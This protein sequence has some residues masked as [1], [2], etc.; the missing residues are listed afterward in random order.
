MFASM[1][2][3]SM[4]RLIH[5]LFIHTGHR[6]W[7]VVV[8]T[9]LNAMTSALGIALILPLL[10]LL[11]PVPGIAPLQVNWLNPE[12]LNLESILLLYLVLVSLSVWIN[13]QTMVQTSILVQEYTKHLRVRLFETLFASD[14][15]YIAYQKKSD[16][17]NLFTLEIA[18]ISSSVTAL[19]GLISG[20]LIMISHIVLAWYLSPRLTGFVL[21]SGIIVFIS[22]YTSLGRVRRLA[23]SLYQSNQTWQQRLHEQLYG[24]KEIRSYGIEAR[25]VDFFRQAT[26]E[27]EQQLVQFAKEQ[28]K[29][30]TVFKI[31]AAAV[32]SLFF[33]ISL[34]VLQ[35]EVSTLLV[36]VL[37]FGR[38]WPLFAA[39]QK[40]IQ[41]F[42]SGVPVYT[43]L[44]NKMEAVPKRSGSDE[45]K[46][47]FHETLVIDR[48]RYSYGQ[49]TGIGVSFT[50]NAGQMVA[51]M[52]ASGTGKSTFLD[53]LL[54]L[55]EPQAGEIRVDGK[56][57]NARR[58]VAWREQISYIPQSAFLFHGTI[59]E[60]ILHFNPDLTDEA[61]VE[62]L[63]LAGATFVFDL[64]DGI[65]TMIGDFGT[66]LS[67]G[68]QQKIILARA[69][70]KKPRILLLDE[71]T[72][73]LDREQEVM[74]HDTLRQLTSRMTILYITHRREIGQ[75]ADAIYQMETGTFERREVNHSK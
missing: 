42:L 61:L 24:M 45:E 62:A 55:L 53:L 34:S 63:D 29:P 66:R 54:G 31:V 52:G 32:I 51:I 2:Q 40:N 59:R 18:R 4:W 3:A 41:I 43:L 72:N 1:N 12:W 70:A 6:L 7:Y 9:S 20:V 27:V 11:F 33:Y 68:Q 44:L 64:P 21:V 47:T 26:E 8:W 75:L 46:L 5:D 71:A 67:G 69:L 25:Q 48:V 50:V 14:Y 30:D 39:F 38:L 58:A 15:S 56:T 60:N 13:R 65:E 73:A 23:L 28:S 35:E 17:L 49:T 74:F 16:V 57:L 19:I 10:A 22:L 37:L 36:I